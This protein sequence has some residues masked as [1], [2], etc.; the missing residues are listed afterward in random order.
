V[1]IC[2]FKPEDL[3]WQYVTAG[4]SARPM[5]RRGE[6]VELLWELGRR[7]TAPA[8]FAAMARMAT[9]PWHLRQAFFDGH[10][11]P[12][13]QGFPPD[14]Q[15][16]GVLCFDAARRA[17]GPLP[18]ELLG[19]KVRFLCALPVVEADRQRITPENF[20]HYLKQVL[21]KVVETWR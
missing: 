3:P 17:G 2:E 21:G 14:S 12:F 10:V 6:S 20:A 5:P 8:I 4:L 19:R 13:P 7:V 15:F 9:M 16:R 11:Q 1:V 18:A